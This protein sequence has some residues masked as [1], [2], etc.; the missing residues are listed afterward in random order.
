MLGKAV[1]ATAEAAEF[2]ASV[3]VIYKF[4]EFIVQILA[5]ARGI[6]LNKATGKDYATSTGWMIA[7]FGVLMLFIPIISWLV[8]LGDAGAFGM[9][10]IVAIIL[11]LGIVWM[12][13]TGIYSWD[14][15]KSPEAGKSR[16]EIAAATGIQ[17]Y[18]QL[19]KQ[20]DE[21]GEFTREQSRLGKTR[22]QIAEEWE[23][24]AIKKGYTV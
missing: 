4:F 11:T 7:G 18:L 22:E 6:P 12:V 15:D 14:W 21:S 19:Q 10:I 20:W 13:K 2:V 3:W 17:R 9:L 23:Q 24:I 8:S 1:K 16:E 5:E